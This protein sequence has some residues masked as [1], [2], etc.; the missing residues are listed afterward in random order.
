ML[1]A[2]LLHIYQPP[3]Q[4]PDVFKEIA[5][6][7]YSKILR[8]LAR[9]S[10]A[11]VTVNAPA[12]L[13]EQLDQYHYSHLLELLRKLVSSRQVELLGS[14]AYHPLLF[15]LPGGE[16]RR[17]IRL[18]ERINRRYFGAAWAPRGFFPPELGASDRVLEIIEALGYH[19]VILEEIS[20][21]APATAGT[22]VFRRKGGRLGVLFRN[23]ALSLGVAFGKLTSFAALKAQAGG[24]KAV[25]LALDGETFGWHRPQQLGLLEELFSEARHNRGLSLLT[26]SE[27]TER[28]PAGS[29][30][31]IGKTSW[32][33]RVVEGGRVYFPRWEDPGNIIHQMQWDLTDLAIKV[34]NGSRF[35]IRDLKLSLG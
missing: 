24:R 5:K 27:L 25:I 26:L 2:L 28:I 15:K 7:S 16:I 8:L 32:G 29:E 22:R 3:T 34:V 12:S 33:E 35:K 13:I 19:W 31:T 20:G 17:Q 14:A 1:L 10:E 6:D 18:N 23:R 4:F 11:R 9:Y 21:V 30:V